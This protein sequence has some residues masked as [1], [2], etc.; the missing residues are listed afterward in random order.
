M[1]KHKNSSNKFLLVGV[2]LIAVLCLVLINLQKQSVAEEMVPQAP[3]R[4]TPK[5]TPVTVTPA[6]QY[7]NTRLGYTLT[8]PAGATLTYTDNGV[9]K[10][11]K[12]LPADAHEIRI[13]TGNTYLSI[14]D[15][16]YT[17][18]TGTRTQGTT[19][20]DGRSYRSIFTPSQS[21]IYVRDGLT[22][23]YGAAAPTSIL[24][25]LKIK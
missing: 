2:V 4:I 14:S 5:P 21:T 10:S 19:V 13:Y 6:M 24:A 3:V 1:N 20:I 17:V 18:N 16:S 15:K 11:V 9:S 25:S 12:T 22:L 8:I 7:T 23:Y